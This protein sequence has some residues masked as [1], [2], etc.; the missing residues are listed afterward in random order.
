MKA[1]SDVITADATI[2]KA[3]S[4]GALANVTASVEAG[5]FKVQEAELNLR[6]QVE[7]ARLSVTQLS[8]SKRLAE[9]AQA[10]LGNIYAQLL[11]S[12]YSSYSI[13]QSTSYSAG[14]SMAYNT[15]RSSSC[16]E[17]G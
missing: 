7:S 12:T 9:T 8:D 11:A 3:K 1:F 14:K 13:S 6:A 17:S 4:D 5:R 10:A 15:S 16:T 2:Y